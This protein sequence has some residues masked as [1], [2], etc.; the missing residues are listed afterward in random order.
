MAGETLSF[1][2]TGNSESAAKAF[3]GT[4]DSAALAAKGAKLCEA[5][6]RRTQHDESDQEQI[7]RL[8]GEL[9]VVKARLRFIERQ[10]GWDPSALEFPA[11]DAP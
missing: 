5:A 6:L 2:I 3:R 8:S 11:Q 4:A 7:R 1:N 9:E 10:L